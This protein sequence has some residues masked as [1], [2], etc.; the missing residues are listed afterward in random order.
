MKKKTI[1]NLFALGL[2]GT[3]VYFFILFS[4]PIV[5]PK[6]ETPY[7]TFEDRLPTT[8]SF[9]NSD[10]IYI[11]SKDVRITNI[12]LNHNELLNFYDK[13]GNIDYAITIT[14]L[15]SV[16][17]DV[18]FTDLHNG[19]NYEYKNYSLVARLDFDTGFYTLE[20]EDFSSNSR[21]DQFIYSKSPVVLTKLDYSSYRA[22]LFLPLLL[23]VS[24]IV[25]DY[26][27]RHKELEKKRLIQGY[28]REIGKKEKY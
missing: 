6:F 19:N 12:I 10:S 9:T 24:I 8:M 25:V 11:Y 14:K 16:I 27:T 3:S 5:V 26:N 1:L 13:Y 15:D 17:D 18:V 23:G 20:Y 7:Y 22:I 4:S 2:V 28:K 21:G